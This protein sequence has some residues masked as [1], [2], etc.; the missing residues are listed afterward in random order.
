MPAKQGGSGEPPG[1]TSLLVEVIAIRLLDVVCI[2]VLHLSVILLLGVACG[3]PDDNQ[4]AVGLPDL[5]QLSDDQSETKG[6][7]INHPLTSRGLWPGQGKG[8]RGGVIREGARDWRGPQH[9]VLEVGLGHGE[10]DL[11]LL[12]GGR[13]G[14]QRGRRDQRRRWPLPHQRRELQHLCSL[15]L[16]PQA[17][18]FV[19]VWGDEWPVEQSGRTRSGCGLWRRPSID[20]CCFLHPKSK[21]IL[22][23]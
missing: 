19:L 14:E 18:S 21:S 3:L 12:G 8:T 15:L 17:R 1:S 2:V 22:D 11:V 5:I 20:E 13:H 4:V 16:P 7:V 9:L 6:S 10:E 23:F